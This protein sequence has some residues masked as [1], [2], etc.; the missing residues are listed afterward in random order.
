M[1]KIKKYRLVYT[2][3]YCFRVNFSVCG[4]VRVI[5]QWTK[6]DLLSVSVLW[7]CDL[8]YRMYTPSCPGT[9]Q[10]PSKMNSP[11]ILASESVRI[12]IQHIISITFIHTLV[13]REIN[14]GVQYVHKT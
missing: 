3:V 12:R 10:R 5:Y 9:H 2:Y 13:S 8:L 11:I 7:L 6:R 4:I 14:L 1:F